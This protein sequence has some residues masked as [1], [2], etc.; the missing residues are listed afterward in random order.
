MEFLRDPRQC[1]GNQLV[2]LFLIWLI[3]QLVIVLSQLIMDLGPISSAMLLHLVAKEAFVSIVIVCLMI[4]TC[5]CD[6]AVLNE[7]LFVPSVHQKSL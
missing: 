6:L 2:Q 4:C 5:T 1:L 7:R 3:T